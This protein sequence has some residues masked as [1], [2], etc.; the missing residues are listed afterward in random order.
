MPSPTTTNAAKTVLVT[1]ANRGLG[2]GFVRHYLDAGWGVVA[3]ARFP[4]EAPELQD[5]A[6]RHP[7]QLIQVSL[8]LK[9]GGSV[10]RLRD[11]VVRRGIRLDLLINNAGV[12]IP[13]AFGEWT[14]EILMAN[15]QINAVGPAL[16]AQAMAPLMNPGAK[17]INV[18]SGVG[19]LE[20]HIAPGEPL[21]GYAMSKAAMNMLTRRLA[22][23]LRPARITVVSVNPGWVRTRMGGPEATNSVEDAVAWMAKTIDQLSP[24]QSGRFLGARGEP[25]PW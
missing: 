2:L 17:L 3:A 10:L 21:D 25:I 9:C 14:A 15:L 8:D 13:A 22:E 24:A 7:H 5:L 12:S 23:R 11:E 16:A 4:A 19:S 1:G 18:S 6:V 20:L